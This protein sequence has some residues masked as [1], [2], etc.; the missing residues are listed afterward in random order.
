MRIWIFVWS[1]ILLSAFEGSIQKRSG[2]CGYGQ[3]LA[4][5]NPENVWD[6]NTYCETC[7]CGYSNEYCLDYLGCT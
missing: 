7:N 4:Y 1:A 5:S 6:D 2:T 3:F